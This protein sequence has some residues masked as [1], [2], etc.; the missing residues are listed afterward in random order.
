M[1]GDMNSKIGESIRNARV[2]KKMRQ[3]DLAKQIGV[4]QALISKW[5]KSKSIP[6]GDILVKLALLLDIVTEIFPGYIKINSEDSQPV[7]EN[8]QYVTVDEFKKEM[9]ELKK[10]FG[11][12]QSEAQK[13]IAVNQNH[14]VESMAAVGKDAKI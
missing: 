3:E 8:N 11:I 14:A 5:E 12:Y 7:P 6:S 1:G 10:S 13:N 4:K 9:D 2:R